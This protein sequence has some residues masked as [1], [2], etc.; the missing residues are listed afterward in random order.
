MGVAP[1]GGQCPLRRRFR[2]SRQLPRWATCR[3]ARSKNPGS[4]PGLCFH[5]E[6]RNHAAIVVGIGK[7]RIEFDR[8]V[9]V[10]GRAEVKDADR[11]R[12]ERETRPSWRVQ[13]ELRHDPAVAPVPVGGSERH[14]GGLRRAVRRPGR[15]APGR[16]WREPAEEPSNGRPCG[17][18]PFAR[19]SGIHCTKLHTVQAKMR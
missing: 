9:V 8:L 2:T 13:L 14:R 16:G 19:Q 18:Q 7:F 4:P 5:R 3:Y 17:T 15:P 10:G 1:V 12:S 11:E 6:L